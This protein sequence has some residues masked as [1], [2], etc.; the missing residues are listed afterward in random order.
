MKKT[1]IVLFFTDQQRADTCGCYGSADGLTPNLDALA[2]EGVVFENAYSCQPVC[3]PARAVLQTGNYATQSGCFRNFIQLKDNGKTL[4]HRLNDCGYTTNYIGK[5]HLA[6]AQDMGRGPIEQERRCG[7]NGKWLAADLLEFT[8]E[9]YH[10][11]LYNERNEKVYFEDEYRT[12][13]L[14]RQAIQFLDSYTDERPFF[15]MVSFL[16]PHHQNNMNRF[17]APHGYA[18]KFRDCTAPTDLIQLNRPPAD[19]QENLAD[20]YGA[21]HR[22]DENFGSIVEK[23]KQQ[24]IYEDT[25]LIFA[26]DHGN[27]FR[28]RKGE[29]KRSCHEASIK[30]PMVLRGGPFLG[31]KRVAPF[32][33]LQDIL[34][35]LVSLAG[36]VCTDT[37][38]KN[39][40]NLLEHPTPLEEDYAFIQV[41]ESQVGRA[42]C[43]H[44]WKYSVTA[45]H[46]NAWND[47]DSDVYVEQYLYDLEND[48]Y[49]L[50]N[51]I[52]DPVFDSVKAKMKEKLL[53][54]I[55]QVEKKT[56]K[57]LSLTQ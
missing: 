34:P 12:D 16:E 5:F 1:N 28:T 32:A 33:G 51:L 53:E 22:L 25:L 54:K 21:I 39:L 14:T 26:S 29:Y 10:G 43:S 48:P 41:S 31:G 35:T 55:A 11:F 15:L 20:Y 17:V 8:S 27:H 2:R 3:G 13:F 52:A 6:Q 45:P 44:K 19:W 40:E 42:I 23:L 50:K 49:E 37:Q 57:I 56:P 7:Y 30:I 18:E 38:G 46:R 9:P 4:A 47:S 36:G 24:G